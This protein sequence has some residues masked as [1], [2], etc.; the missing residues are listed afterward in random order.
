MMVA[1]QNPGVTMEV[2]CIDGGTI[3]QVEQQ[4]MPRILDEAKSDAAKSG[5]KINTRLATMSYCDFL[6]RFG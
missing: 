4:E 3:T 2:G 1:Q 5:V 6:A